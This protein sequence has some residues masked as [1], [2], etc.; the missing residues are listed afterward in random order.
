[1]RK[2]N[3]FLASLRAPGF[4]LGRKEIITPARIYPR[5]I[6]ESVVRFGNSDRRHFVHLGPDSRRSQN[7]YDDVVAV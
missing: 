5:R 2:T 6:N 3:L 1:M 4:F 7:A